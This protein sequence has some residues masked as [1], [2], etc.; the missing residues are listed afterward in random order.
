MIHL[1]RRALVIGAGPAGLATLRNL[2]QLGRFDCVQLVER[3]DDIGGVWYLDDV[4][5]DSVL[6]ESL[7]PR[8]PSPA[9]PGLVGN[10]LPEFLSFYGHPFP[11]PPTS[12]EEPFPSLLETQAYLQAFA[13]PFLE[14]GSIRLNIEVI[15]VEE[16]PDCA[17]WR[18]V[19]KDWNDG[20]GEIIEECWDAV[21]V[22]AGCYD[23]ASWP[24]IEGL[25]ELKHKGLALHARS[26]RGAEGFEGKRA[27][28]IEDENS[29][30]D[31]A[32]PLSLLGCPP[33]YRSALH[34]VKI[35]CLPNPRIEDVPPV[36]E[37]RCHLGAPFD[38]SNFH[39]IAEESEKVS[40]TLEDGTEIDNID[41]LFVDTGYKPHSEMIHVISQHDRRSLTPLPSVIPSTNARTCRIPHLY[42]HIL[43]AYNPTLAFIGAVTASLPFVVADI[44]SLWL[45]LAW[46]GEIKI[47]STP[48]ERLQFEH[49]LLVDIEPE[50]RDKMGQVV[51]SA[52]TTYSNLG[53]REV[54]YAAGL[55]KDIV[56]VRP[57][58]G[59]LLLEWDDRLE[60]AKDNMFLMKIKALE[61]AKQKRSKIIYETI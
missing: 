7:R 38:S 37:F 34:S 40:V 46:N 43:Y 32:T 16:L 58:L 18:V 54:Q 44:S 21:A 39:T 24:D 3:R 35:P 45:T 14:N 57:G 41:V 17:G 28:V 55:R 19:M 12:P 23:N 25:K 49:D 8:W 15:S 42:Q 5:A 22:C 61:W 52:S 56:N 1:K 6:D 11:Q 33:V 2:I 47:P 13:K 60:T 48:A 4:N 50:H 20:L 31:M 26:W 29:T 30:L 59:S 27:L 36:K 51:P 10:V 53:D 9:Y